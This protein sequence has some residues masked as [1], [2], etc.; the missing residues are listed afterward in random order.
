[1]LTIS[2]VPKYS[3]VPGSIVVLVGFKLIDVEGSP[4]SESR[5]F[6]LFTQLG[7]ISHKET[8]S[9]ASRFFSPSESL[10]R[11]I[12]FSVTNHKF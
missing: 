8:E 5:V 12:E 6:E 9:D 3:E 1:M 10:S 7:C 11:F 2:R 4:T